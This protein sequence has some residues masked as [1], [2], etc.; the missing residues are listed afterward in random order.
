MLGGDCNLVL[1]D[2]MDSYNYRRLNNVRTQQKVLD[3]IKKY[4]LIDVFRERC[5]TANRYHS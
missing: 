1:G 3:M 2:E 4:D 5:T